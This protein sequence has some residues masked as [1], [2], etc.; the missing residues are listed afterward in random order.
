MADGLN[1]FDS[2]HGTIYYTLPTY[3]TGASYISLISLCEICLN[4]EL[5][6]RD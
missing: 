4:D 3:G 6:I 5:S 1:V 2:F